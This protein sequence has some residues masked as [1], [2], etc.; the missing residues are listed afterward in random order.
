MMAIGEAVPLTS[1][2]N[3]RLPA[4]CQSRKYSL[5]LFVFLP[6]LFLYLSLHLL[7]SSGVRFWLQSCTQVLLCV[8]L[9]CQHQHKLVTLS[10]TYAV[11]R[12]GGELHGGGR[13]NL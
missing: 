6:T 12:A 5:H 1:W 4:S 13:R 10:S 8:D 3:S 2:L 9:T 11:L 7:G